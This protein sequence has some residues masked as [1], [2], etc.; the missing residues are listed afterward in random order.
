[1]PLTLAN[2]H[3]IETVVA[4]TL[5]VL[6]NIF[7]KKKGILNSSDTPIFTRLLIQVVLPVFIFFQL[8]R[9]PP[10]LRYLLP[11]VAM[12]IAGCGTLLA[13]WIIGNLLGFSRATTGAL[14]IVSSFGSSALL[15]YPLIEYT[16]PAD[17]GA[18][19]EAILISELAVGLPI[20]T[21]CP[22]VA[23]HFGDA[24]QTAGSPLATLLQYLRSPIFIAV[25]LG[26]VVS[27]FHPPLQ[28]PF[29]APILEA[30]KMIDGTLAA[31]A[32]LILGMQIKVESLKRL[33]PIVAISAVLQ[34]G[35]QP[36]L[37]YGQA[38]FYHLPSL[39]RQVLVLIAA[40]PSAVLGPVFAVRYKCDGELAS[41]VT[42][43]NILLGAVGI[44]VVFGLLGR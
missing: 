21:L 37:A 30:A 31:L 6:L 27:A 18:M 25:V 2:I 17:P 3:L 20:F 44:P 13:A 23:M 41:T 1:M 26:F 42:F 12:F 5:I 4:F 29:L 43:I 16:F 40:M 10:G 19:T 7:L 14:M 38:V 9:Y 28:S 35:L 11:V 8:L 22:L 39:E 34:M 15:G 36:L 24:S 32:C 33:L